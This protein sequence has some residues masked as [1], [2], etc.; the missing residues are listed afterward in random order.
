MMI[1]GIIN[2]VQKK[3]ETKYIKKNTKTNV[4]SYVNK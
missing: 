3:T 4:F 2:Q 1:P